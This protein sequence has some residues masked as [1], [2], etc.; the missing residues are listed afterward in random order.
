M[1]R[2]YC[3]VLLLPT[4]QRS[5]VFS[6]LIADLLLLS[7]PPQFPDG[8]LDLCAA[9]TACGKRLFTGTQA[10]APSTRHPPVDVCAYVE[11]RQDT[12]RRHLDVCS[13]SD[14]LQNYAGLS[15]DLPGPMYTNCSVITTDQTPSSKHSYPP[16]SVFLSQ[17]R[18]PFPKYTI[19]SKYTRAVSVE[20]VVGFGILM[21][22]LLQRSTNINFRNAS[23]VLIN[24]ITD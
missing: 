6:T 7:I 2:T 12:H 17:Q 10:L 22:H 24:W 20:V 16:S 8:R 1:A 14:T 4:F 18:V 11:T 19:L 3:R 15:V 9:L 21:T 13:H 23:I 5:H